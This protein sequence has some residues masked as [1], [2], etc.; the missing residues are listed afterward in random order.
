MLVEISQV[1]NAENSAI[2]L[3]PTDNVAI[4]RDGDVG[5]VVD[6]QEMVVRQ[7]GQQLADVQVDM[8]L[9]APLGGVERDAPR[10]VR[11]RLAG[12][13]DGGGPV[14]GALLRCHLGE[15]LRVTAVKA[16]DGEPAVRLVGVGIVQEEIRC[17]GRLLFGFLAEAALAG[18]EGFRDG[19]VAV[20]GA[21]VGARERQQA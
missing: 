7:V 4:A 8:A 15:L 20:A 14:A 1:P 13:G 3:H 5:G 11:P 2:H 18:F 17:I 9:R 10:V 6:H 16:G 12:L 19:D 21:H